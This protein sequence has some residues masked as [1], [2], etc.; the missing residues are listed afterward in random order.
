MDC[1]TIAIN[2]RTL[3]PTQY[4]RYNFQALARLAAAPIGGGEDG[5]FTLDEGDCDNLDPADLETGQYDIDAGFALVLSDLGRPDNKS[6]RQV[7]V[8]GET[9]GVL[10]VDITYDQQRTHRA[11]LEPATTDQ[12]QDHLQ[13]TGSR[14]QKGRHVQIALSNTDGCDFSVDAISLHLAN[15]SGRRGA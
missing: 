1:L 12:H 8:A 10:Q 7:L 5:L 2:L 6:V 14:R 15:R 13:A 3:A 11:P 9:D 4:Q